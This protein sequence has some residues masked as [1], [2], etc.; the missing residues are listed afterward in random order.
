MTDTPIQPGDLR[1]LWQSMPATPV[2][3]TAEDMR[4]RALAFQQKVRRR[5]FGEYAAAATVIG[6][7]GWYASFPE[8]ATPLWPIANLMIIAGVLLVT[9]NLNRLARAAVPPASASATDLIAF[10]RNQYTRQRDALKSVWLWYIAPLIPGMILW[11]VASAVGTPTTN[12]GRTAVV[13]GGE[14]LITSLVFGVVILLNLL[15]AARLQRLIDDL[16]NFKDQ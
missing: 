6:V 11:S 9:W 15:G 2:T 16:E 7:F 13:L 5:N 4:A 1:S 3:I 14:V 12:P 10:Q 8:P